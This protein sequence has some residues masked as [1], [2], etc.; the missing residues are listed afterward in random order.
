[1]AFLGH[2][3]PEV[4]DI[5]LSEAADLLGQWDEACYAL[6][7]E[8]DPREALLWVSR[9]TQS[10]RRASR[11]MG[12]EE[13]SQTLNSTEEYVRLVLRAA[14]NPGPEVART[15]TL[16]HGVLSRW[17]VGL[18][19][20][21]HH[22]ESLDEVNDSIR[23]QKAS[24]QSILDEERALNNIR[25]LTTHDG[26]AEEE[27]R[28]DETSQEQATASKALLENMHW[29]L[30]AETEGRVDAL[31]HLAGKLSAYGLSLERLVRGESL[32]VH[33][34]KQTVNNTSHFIEHLCGS[35]VELRKAPLAHF[36]ERLAGFAIES[37]QSKG[38]SVQFDYD[39]QGVLVDKKLLSTLWEPVSRVVRWMIENSFEIP[40]ERVKSGKLP[41]GFVRMQAS[42]K[43]HL[44]VLSIEDDGRGQGDGDATPQGL[45]L[46]NV[47]ESI[48]SQLRVH[49]AA[50][51][52][53]AH[54]G[55]S[56]RIDIVFP[57][58]PFLM[59]TTTVS[60]AQRRF[61]LPSHMVH[62]LIEPGTFSTH[63][64]RGDKQ[65]VEY[66]GKLYP[67]VTLNEAVE[68]APL[69]RRRVEETV[70]IEK[71]YVA[72]VRYGRDTVAVGIDEVH[73]TELRIVTPLQRHLARARGL[74]GTIIDAHGIPVFA[75]DMFEV[76][77]SFL[78]VGSEREVA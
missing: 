14:S 20:D 30:H 1:M 15:L 24:I 65:L 23:T 72:L 26:S 27:A 57:A 67:F 32:Q 36:L 78:R 18:R 33:D 74:I 28:T 11:G 64:L 47:I 2:I 3:T 17:V 13:F 21:A 63:V 19:T 46:R 39:G 37:A 51:L 35:A 40:E 71:G 12:L 10:L 53:E 60:C 31:I 61:A 16:T 77:E 50:L 45:V 69:L 76:I 59:E 41:M 58:S 4:V 25:T 29:D 9:C 34:L 49:T 48:R 73:Q 62:A 42:S 52:V 66:S 75:V 56:T 6:E 54:L 70:A 43:G 7:N 55:R 5:F 38:C 22:T 68:K 8:G 44:I